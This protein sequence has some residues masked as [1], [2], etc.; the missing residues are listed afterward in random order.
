MPL[1]TAEWG[2]KLDLQPFVLENRCSCVNAIST[3]PL[4]SVICT[5]KRSLVVKLLLFTMLVIVFKLYW[6]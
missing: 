5:K 4:L 3:D 2:G 6:R 1:H